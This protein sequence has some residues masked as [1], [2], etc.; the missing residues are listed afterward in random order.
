MDT[1]RL[2]RGKL[3]VGR[4]VRRQ[5]AQFCFSTC[6][7]SCFVGVANQRLRDCTG[8]G[9][10]TGM[11][12][13]LAS[14]PPR[15]PSRRQSVAPCP[16]NPHPSSPPSFWTLPP[17]IQLWFPGRRFA[18]SWRRTGPQHVVLHVAAVDQRRERLSSCRRAAPRVPRRGPSRRQRRRL[19]LRH[20]H[21]ELPSLI[22]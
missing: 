12:P 22:S 8:T 21:R 20:R 9:A 11:A 2:V 1:H 5:P 18:P 10:G 17:L 6:W 4:M 3:F 19:Q 15:T 7:G 16:P 13:A 14:K